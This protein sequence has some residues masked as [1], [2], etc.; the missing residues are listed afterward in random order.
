MPSF[1]R[2]P[3]PGWRVRPSDQAATA[4]LASEARLRPLTARIL[5]SRG[6]HDPSSVSRFLAPRLA[7]LRPPDG[8]AD[9][10]RALERLRAAAWAASVWA[11]SGTTTST[12]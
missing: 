9:L 7:D 5:V 10:E 12:A 11:C 4:R 1:E 6:L 2:A 8:M 3:G